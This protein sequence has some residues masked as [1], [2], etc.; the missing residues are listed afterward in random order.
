MSSGTD[1]ARL[2]RLLALFDELLD[3]EEGPRLERLAALREEDPASAAELEAM[4]LAD[5]SGAAL[6]LEGRLREIDPEAEEALAPGSALGPF[7]IVR[8]LGRGGMGEVY[9]ATRSQRGFEQ[10]VALKV[11]RKGLVDLQ[12]IERFHRECRIQ[13]RLA[14][15]AIVPLIDAG[16]GEDGR[17]FL[18]M[19]YVDGQPITD[20]ADARQLSIAKRMRLVVDCCRAVES[21]HVRL[22]VHRD[23]K[24]SNILVGE[25]G[26]VRLL[27]FGIAKVLGDEDGE[28]G[29]LTRL[30]PA[31][32][33]PRRAAPEQLRGEPCSTATD[34]WGL[35]VLLYELLTGRLPFENTSGQLLEIE[36]EIRRRGPTRPSRALPQG[37]EDTAR[38]ALEQLAVARSTTPRRLSRELTGDVEVVLAR[39]LAAE[40]ERR[41]TSAAA[42]A[43]DLERLLAGRPVAARADSWVYRSRRFVGRHRI[44]VTAAMLGLTFLATLGVTTAVQSRR[45][46]Q[47]RDRATLLERQ[48]TAMVELLTELFG[49]TAPNRGAGMGD[50]SIDQLLQDGAAKA[51][52]LGSTPGVQALMFATLGRIRLERSEL[53]AGRELLEKARSVADA[54]GADLL[55]TDRLALE[56]DYTRALALID[57][58]EAARVLLEPLV[59][60]LEA[61]GKT[62]SADLAEALAQLSRVAPT[63]QSFPL[64]ERALALRR[65]LDPP[66]PVDLASS[67]DALAY[68]AFRNGDL[69]K[70]RAYWLEGLPLLEKELGE[71]D[72]RTLTTLN[73][74]AT[75]TVDPTTQLVLLRRLMAIQERLVGRVSAPVANIE[76]NIGVA[77]AQLADYEGAE[78]AMR[79]SHR[80]RTQVLG[81]NHRETVRTLR[82]VARVVELRGRYAEALS[83]FDQVLV[84]LPATGIPHEGWASFR[85]QRAALLWR[86]GRQ[87]E[88]S[89]VLEEAL[90]QLRSDW[91]AGH[92]EI[93][94]AMLLEER[95]AAAAGEG[96]KAVALGR[97]VLAMRAANLNEAHPKVFEA[98]A[99]LGRSLLLAGQTEEGSALLAPSLPELGTWGLLHPADRAAL[100]AV[101][102]GRQDG[103]E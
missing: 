11:L 39:A 46:A 15:P 90:A 44:A 70:A 66:R 19:Q 21:A 22:V 32:M 3:L 43:D 88:A 37:T 13:A 77:L 62:E 86:L 97:Q 14:H 7:R 83:I 24:P 1:P 25:G 33:T 84:Q 74:L 35:G 54:A 2:Q 27:D 28:E 72:L 67:L 78:A 8:R 85:V 16:I 73:N 64:A 9:L 5:Q 61:A 10:S 95:M 94:I 52:T 29:D 82:N 17:P 57:E 4:L 23:L 40:P 71:E 26:G 100:H 42:L 91:P 31:P 6:E 69:A 49:A 47:E 81:A 76:N 101:Y 51:D 58:V 75:V 98:R 59:A 87:A 48:S 12:A 50:I 93:A 41:Y 53:P 102:D 34:V 36:K 30:A 96:A 55:A 80:L 68:L 20:F 79:E 45:V 18:A 38:A 89:A 99:E 65:G 63:P 92:E 60:R 56:L 103:R